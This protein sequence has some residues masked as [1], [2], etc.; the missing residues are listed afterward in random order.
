MKEGG[1]E[2][3]K[4]GRKEGGREGRKK[5]KKEGR[6]EDRREEKRRG[7]ERKGKRKELQY[8]SLKK[9]HRKKQI[10]VPLG[11]TVRA[12]SG[13]SY[14]FIWKS[15]RETKITG[16]PEKVHEAGVYIIPTNSEL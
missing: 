5:R 3:R 8:R 7:K 11:R 10:S 13:I 4:E 6:K 1:R 9:M 16:K 2:G 15:F 12:W 14:F